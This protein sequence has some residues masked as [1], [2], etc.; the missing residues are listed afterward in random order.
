MPTPKSLTLSMNSDG[1]AAYYTP[2]IRLML[3][4]HIPYLLANQRSTLIPIDPND[5]HK[6][7]YDLNGLLLSYSIPAQLHWIVMRLNNMTSPIEF[8]TAMTGLYIPDPAVIERLKTM[9]TTI[10]R[11]V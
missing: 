9:H 5:A 3:E 11:M 7:E 4:L 6:Y 2:D 1:P 8:T 10:H